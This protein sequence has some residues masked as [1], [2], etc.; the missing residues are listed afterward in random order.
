[1]HPM[2][3]ANRVEMGAAQAA[4]VFHAGDVATNSANATMGAPFLS[5]PVLQHR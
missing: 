4:S 2:D 5:T 3:F 1:M